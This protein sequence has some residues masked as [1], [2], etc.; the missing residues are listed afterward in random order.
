MSQ[1]SGQ[2]IPSTCGLCYNACSILVHREGDVITK[3]EGNPESSIGKGHL[4]GK[5]VAGIMTHYDPDRVT[6][7][8]RRTNPVKGMGVDPG[9]KEISWE[10]A[11]EEIAGK[12]KK[13]HKED[14]RRLFVQRTTT[15]TSTRPP[16]NAFAAAF[17][18]RNSW[19]AGGGLHCGNGA[20]LVNG[21]FHAS[22][23][24]VPDFQY[25]EYALYFGASK[26][27]GAGHVACTNMLDAAD[28]RVR[29]MR[30]V[31]MDPMCNFA[32]AK[33]DEWVPLLP[34]TDAALALAMINL[35]L[36]DLEVWDA[37]FLANKTNAPYLIG[38]DGL[39][40]RDAETGKPLIWDE[41]CNQAVA[42]DDP[43]L[44]QPAL[45]GEYSVQ[46]TQARPAFVLLREHVRQFT[47]QWAEKITSVP[48]S[49]VCRLAEEFATQARVG[50]TIVIDG[51][52]LPYRP[53]AAIY[54][55]GA[56]GHKNSLYNCFAISLLNQVV[57]AADV[58]GGCLGFNPT[59]YGHPDTGKPFYH[60]TEGP[61]GL[62]VTGSWVSP[63]LPYPFPD[64][65]KPE[66][67][68]LSE[69]F[70]MGMY[71]STM[72]SSDQEEIWKKFDLPFPPEVLLNC[73]ANSLMSV[74]NAQTVAETLKRIPFIVCIEIALTETTEFADIILPDTNYLESVESRP[75]FPLIFNHPA[76][77]G[78]WTWPIKQPVLDPPGQCRPTGE[79]LMELAHRIGIGEEMNAA[80]NVLMKLE[81]EQR[82]KHTE[83][84]TYEEVCDRELKS[85]FGQERGLQWFKE[86]GL[87]KWPKKVEEVYWRAFLDVRA[88]IYWEY[89]IGVNSKA[90][91]IAQ[92][93][94]F[95]WDEAYYE[96]LPSWLPCPSHEVEDESFDLFGFYYRDTVHTNSFTYQNPWL[97]ETSRLDP[98]SLTIAL[99]RRT[100]LQKGLKEGQQV[101]LESTHGRRVQGQIHLTETIHPGCVG[102][103]G[104]AGHWVKTLPV[105]KGKGIFFNDLL[106]IDWEHTS[107][108]NLNLDTCVKVKIVP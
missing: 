36:N 51:H 29:G 60:P 101:W 39:Y 81:G 77:L 90:R 59:C 89:L 97:D 66:N 26:G 86:H 31:V 2:W 54:F 48:A 85:N 73:G 27:H 46:G 5:G 35:I 1:A 28:A 45:Q 67:M 92:E 107:P 79:V 61:D 30:M 49:T 4:C 82:L 44:S 63:H 41:V 14:P 43:E 91:V 12:L 17:G 3:I 50:S 95:P 74:G 106:E 52:T 70:P 105:A 32:S 103:G 23:S 65:K 80:F 102:V 75:N 53:V 64:P 10:E 69:L 94:D 22:W 20:H 88:P 7:P 19:A 8:L 78:E 71:G 58:P 16:I 108:V 33:A 40:L 56:Q 24:S 37:P 34:G 15:N 9:W 25:C 104:C 93:H 18:T 99:N 6:V 76:G 68:S 72:A 96:P 21:I 13:V 100:G 38:P 84:Y 83:R 57:G 87:V 55:R 11:L 47:P 62:M 42:Y 98:F